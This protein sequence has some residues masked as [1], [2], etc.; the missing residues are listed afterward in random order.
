MAHYSQIRAY[1]TGTHRRLAVRLV[2]GAR[3]E[4]DAFK[5]SSRLW[6]QENQAPTSPTATE[7]GFEDWI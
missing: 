5:W 3:I 7:S 2:L 1:I 6:T 4:L